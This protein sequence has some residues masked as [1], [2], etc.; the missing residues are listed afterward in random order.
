MK[1]VWATRGREWGFRFLLDGGFPDP[2]PA[3]DSVF[4]GTEGESAVCRRVGSRVALRFPDPLDRRD[5]AG[6]VIPHDF[7]VLPPLADEIRSVEEGVLVV[8]P[9]VADAYAD[10]WEEPQPPSGQSVRTAFQLAVDPDAAS[11]PSSAND[12][13]L[14][15]GVPG[16]IVRLTKP[17]LLGLAIASVSTVVLTAWIVRR[18]A[19]CHSDREQ[20][21]V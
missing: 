4:S 21:C 6:R 12:S 2:L 16:T 11:N 1:L 3:Y 9:L 7:V 13:G 19:R 17:P 5:S 10:I 8:W 15:G 18:A 20:A 14:A